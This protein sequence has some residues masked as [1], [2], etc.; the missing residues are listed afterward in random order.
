MTMQAESNVKSLARALTVLECFT[1]AEPELGVTDI[2]T[3]LG[4]QKSTIYN[5]LS[6]FQ[7]EKIIEKMEPEGRRIPYRM[8]D[9]GEQL[10]QEEVQRLRKCL[11]DVDRIH[12]T[13]ESSETDKINAGQNKLTPVFAGQ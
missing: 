1:T 11:A 7:D 12:R 9:K 5:I 4:M 3:K 10:F 6:T 8:T 2:A 13:V